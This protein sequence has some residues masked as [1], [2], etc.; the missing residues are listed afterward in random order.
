[1]TAFQALLTGPAGGPA[2]AP[3]GAHFFGR[4]LAIDAPGHSVDVA[5][6][7]VSVGGAAR[8]KGSCPSISSG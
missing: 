3:V 4:Q 6:L 8:P 1:M 2:G 5:Q 7:V